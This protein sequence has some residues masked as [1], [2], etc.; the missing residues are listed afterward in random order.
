MYGMN[1]SIG[2]IDFEV[3]QTSIEWRFQLMGGVMCLCVREGHA[4]H[5]RHSPHHTTPPSGTAS[6]SVWRDGAAARHP[7]SA[8]SLPH[9]GVTRD[10]K[11]GWLN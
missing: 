10:T 8:H 5:H 2:S 6:L 9:A 1:M 7:L 11:W 4:D 3:C